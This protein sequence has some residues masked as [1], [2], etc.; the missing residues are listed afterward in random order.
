MSRDVP[1]RRLGSILRERGVLAVE[2]AVDIAFDICEALANLHAQGMVHGGLVP[3]CILVPWPRAAMTGTVEIFAVAGHDETRGLSA[4]TFDAPRGNVDRAFAAPEQRTATAT[5]DP[6]ADIWAV[7]ALLHRML[8]GSTPAGARWPEGHDVPSGLAHAIEACLA[9]RPDDRPATIDDVAGRIA[10]FSSAPAHCYCRLAERRALS[11]VPRAAVTEPKARDALGALDRLDQ[12]AIDREL[13]VGRP[14]APSVAVVAAAAVAPRTTIH[15]PESIEVESLP[16]LWTLGD[17]I[18]EESVIYEPGPSGSALPSVVPVQ[19]SIPPATASPGRERPYLGRHA[20]VAYAVALMLSAVVGFHFSRTQPTS[21]G[22]SA[23]EAAPPKALSALPPL[24]AL[25]PVPAV[26]QVT[27][28]VAVAPAT[29]APA[30]ATTPR[31]LPD[32]TPPPRQLRGVRATLKA[33]PRPQAEEREAEPPRAEDA[34]LQD[35][36]RR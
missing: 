32:A 30:V 6:R 10:S 11:V 19:L 2:E 4:L 13:A 22:A 21:T 23:S 26:E 16:P 17:E 18:S 5:I 7:G 3:E 29:P 20:L 35:W 24:P 12:A 27:R 33:S 15:P 34:V 36:A 28:A 1:K 31:N 14:R 25:Q 8:V 9:P